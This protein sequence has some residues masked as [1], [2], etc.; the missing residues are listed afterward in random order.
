MSIDIRFLMDEV[1]G[2]KGRINRACHETSI[3]L[4]GTGQATLEEPIER[5][6]SKRD[7]LGMFSDIDWQF[8]GNLIDQPTRVPP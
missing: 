3:S 4:P 2:L 1:K 5:L 7:N 6:I 8:L